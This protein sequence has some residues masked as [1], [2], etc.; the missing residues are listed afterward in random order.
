MKRQSIKVLGVARWA[1]LF[2]GPNSAKAG[3]LLDRVVITAAMHPVNDSSG[4]KRR[5]ARDPKI[6]KKKAKV[7]ITKS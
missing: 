1:K 2:V 7:K 6:R 5:I 3:P 4:S